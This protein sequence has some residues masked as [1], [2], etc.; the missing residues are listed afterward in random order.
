MVWREFFHISLARKCQLLFGLAVLLIIAAALFVPGYC[1]EV[2][3]HQL[4]S[5]R[6]RELAAIALARVN[7]AHRLRPR[8]PFFLESDLPDLRPKPR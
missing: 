6:T 7:P 3:I 2:L 1:M 4:N 8:S 5:R